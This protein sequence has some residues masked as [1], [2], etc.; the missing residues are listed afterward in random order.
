MDRLNIPEQLKGAWDSMLVLTYGAQLDFYENALVRQLQDRCRN[1][2]I[3][4]DDELYR[5]VCQ[6]V[7]ETPGLLRTVNQRY[8]FAGIRCPRG[9]AHAK[10]VLLLNREEGR[11]L[12]GSGNL[13][14][15]GFTLNEELFCRW[16]YR[17]EGEQHLP[18]FV[19]VRQIVD[20]LIERDWF[21]P[22]AAQR[23]EHMWEQAP[24]IR[25]GVDTSASRVR[26]NLDVPFLDQLQSAVAGEDVQELTVLSAF[27]DESVVALDRMLRTLSPRKLVV[28]VQPGEGG[29]SVDPEAL[30][31]VLSGWGGDSEVRVYSTQG[32]KGKAYCHAKMIVAKTGTRAVCLQGSPNM[33]RVAMLLPAG[34]GNFEAANLLEAGRDD[35]DYIWSGLRGVKTAKDVRKIGT[36]YLGSAEVEGPAEQTWRAR[37]GSFDGRDLVIYSTGFPPFTA[38]TGIA[39]EDSLHPVEDLR[40][41]GTA[42]RMRPGESTKD[43]FDAPRSVTLVWVDNQGAE[44][45]SN[46]VVVCNMQRL[47]QVLN[48]N[49]V[50]RSAQTFGTLDLHDDEIESLITE[51]SAGLLQDKAD[52]FRV[53][54]AVKPERVGETAEGSAEVDRID[55]D[56]VRTSVRYKQYISGGV[57]VAHGGGTLLSALLGSINSQFRGLT[58]PTGVAGWDIAEFE[59]IVEDIG[60]DEGVG[61]NDTAA[62]SQAALI[63]RRREE[64]SRQLWAMLS[65]FI[66]RFAEGTF[67]PVFAAHMGPAVVLRNYR[68]ILHLLTLL[69]DRSVV[70]PEFDACFLATTVDGLVLALTSTYLPSIEPE[71]AGEVGLLVRD[72]T[73]VPGT[74]VALGLA[75]NSVTRLRDDALMRLTR[76][77]TQSV[78]ISEFFEITD[79][80]GE[81]IETAG[82]SMLKYESLSLNSTTTAVA[83]A[84]NWLPNNELRKA[85][86][87]SMGATSTA[88]LFDD[89]GAGTKLQESVR[90]MM[91]G[92]PVRSLSPDQLTLG[93]GVWMQARPAGTYRVTVGD[94]GFD[95]MRS[96]THWTYDVAEGKLRDNRGIDIVVVPPVPRSR[97]DERLAM[98]GG[99]GA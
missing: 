38:L 18:E 90:R 81:Q 9:V 47:N 4:C 12:V 93:L 89:A 2:V 98:L 35:F 76:E 13:G 92:A 3:L 71:L 24:W 16:S 61:Q 26:S 39:F 6:Q 77:A 86:G 27:Y 20:G 59:A 80:C 99:D 19:A 28:Y 65:R 14:R 43:A 58:T 23:I 79:A 17:P 1:R 53:A 41:E 75:A 32:L 15:R 57:A 7:A 36:K 82:S 69:L 52:A 70:R 56:A 83:S 88:L 5:S 87:D 63:E 55:W 31:R 67:D 74:L 44:C 42:L 48:A 30:D 96:A 64:A 46:P 29:T 33:S 34:S 22:E 91:V 85:I 21:Q 25:A 37:G 45:R 10:I 95:A 51:M 68:V 94:T 97:W 73:V 40:L 54:G 50:S 78:L 62:E 11:V 8:V 60:E 72:E 66:K 84:A 49:V